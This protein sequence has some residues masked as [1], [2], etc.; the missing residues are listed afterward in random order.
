MRPTYL[1]S[2]RSFVSGW[3]FVTATAT[4]C[5]SAG[6]CCS[7][8]EAA[9][10]AVPPAL[11]R[12]PVVP[13]TAPP[14]ALPTSPHPPMFSGTS[15]SIISAAINR[16]LRRWFFDFMTTPL[17]LRLVRSYLALARER[18][19]LVG[20][21]RLRPRDHLVDALRVH[22]L[23][24]GV[25]LGHVVQAL[26]AG[27]RGR[28]GGVRPARDRAEVDAP[29]AADLL[30]RQGVLRHVSFDVADLHLDPRAF[31]ADHFQS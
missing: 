21:D 12:F 11:I 31:A 27:G 26:G 13:P 18:R 25:F 20:G 15:D 28:A 8:S 16:E 22:A 29:P 4:D 23:G 19:Q 2:A 1:F 5:P 30:L 24:G 3:R 7:P 17:L 9:S 10:A 14:I 6:S